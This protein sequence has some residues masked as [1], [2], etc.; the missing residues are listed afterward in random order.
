MDLKNPGTVKAR[1][2]GPNWAH[3]AKVENLKMQKHRNRERKEKKELSP[4]MHNWIVAGSGENKTGFQE[5]PHTKI[6]KGTQCIPLWG[7]TQ[8]KK[9]K[10]HPRQKGGENK[11]APVSL[12]K[13][14]VGTDS[15][16]K[17]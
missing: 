10:K 13:K 8:Q 16:L 3:W 7:P 9:S 2:T 11:I 4:A 12:E 6:S 17:E 1:R 14:M 5:N 15:L